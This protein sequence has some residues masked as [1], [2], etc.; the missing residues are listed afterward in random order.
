MNLEQALLLV[1][2]IISTQ[3]KKSI[4]DLEYTILKSAWRGQKYS[5][6]AEEYG[7]T[8]GHAKDIGCLLWQL[9][10]EILGKKVTKNNFRT[11]IQQHF[12]AKNNDSFIQLRETASSKFLGRQTALT[13]LQNLV[14]QNH[15]IIVIQGL[16]GIGK[17]SLAQHFLTTG[18]FDLTLEILIAKETANLISAKSLVEEWFYKDLQAESGK[19]FGVTLARLKRYLQTNHVGILID[20]LEPALDQDGKF[21]NSQRD[22]V[23]LLR[24]LADNTV[25]SV[26][27]ITSRDRLCEAD[28]NLYH[29]RLSGL[30][31][32]TWQEYFKLHQ[33]KIDSVCLGKIHHMYGGNAKAMG[34]ICG[35]VCEDFDSDLK[36]YWQE[37]CHIPLAKTDLK[38]LIASQF[39]RLENLDYTAYIL[40]CCLG[41]YRYQDISKIPRSGLLCLLSDL[42]IKDS[43]RVIESLKNRSLI[44]FSQGNYWLH[45]AIQTEARLR[46]QSENP[47]FNRTNSIREISWQRVNKIIAHFYTQKVKQINNIEAGLT[48]LEA[49][50]HYLAIEDFTAAGKVILTSRNNQWGQYLTLGS[51][52]YRLGLVQ[53]LIEVITQVIEQIQDIKDRSELYNILG[54]L[55]WIIGNISQAIWCQ[56]QTL[57]A[58]SKPLQNSAL[59]AHSLY[60]LKMLQ[61]DSLL[62]IGLYKIDLGELSA[63]SQLLQQ[64]INLA[65][66]TKHHPWSE[67]ATLCL[68]LVES[69]QGKTQQSKKVANEFYQLIIQEK[70]SQYN[71]GRFVY[72]IQILG[73]ILLNLH[74]YSK[75]EVI[76]RRAIAFSQESYYTQIKAKSLIGLAIIYRNQQQFSLANSLHQ[77]AINLLAQ[78]GAKSD[79]A[80]ANYQW[81]L[82]LTAIGETK[83]AQQLYNQAIQLFQQIQAPLQIR[84]V[85]QFLL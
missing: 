80:T 7:C 1:D 77:E 38:N 47:T 73:Q 69:Y 65:Q 68:A 24:I 59:D 46:L 36:L 54:D 83:M 6:I 8:E 9:L 40:L 51:S 85:K 43:N 31:L 33:V 13:K 34:I 57:T 56:K 42:A 27:L 84:K 78:I 45:P 50:Y 76:F 53:P 74:E 11:I 16:G 2:K 23:E 41:C 18:N 82:T 72:F 79:L 58:V 64:V 25:K 70:N 63:A 55:Y 26:T 20:N 75:A 17:T 5:V 61:V 81:G 49:Y 71:T 48:A 67:K 30:S 66:Q 39:N 10:S 3:A 22:Y 15:K 29:Y 37:N 28:L 44:E 14:K 62:S 52:L 12:L 4:S 60:Y 19:E 35:S 32:A 21:I